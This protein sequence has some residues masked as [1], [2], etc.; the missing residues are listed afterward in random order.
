MPSLIAKQLKIV[1][2]PVTIRLDKIVV[3]T[4]DAYCRYVDGARDYVITEALSLVFRRDRD[5]AAWRE[6]SGTK[7]HLKSSAKE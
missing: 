3:E 4:L 1:R 6:A 2:E 5:F 7:S